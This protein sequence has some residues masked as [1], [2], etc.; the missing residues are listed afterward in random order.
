MPPKIRWPPSTTPG[1][2]LRE[3]TCIFWHRITGCGKICT[4]PMNVVPGTLP[5]FRKATPPNGVFPIIRK[6]KS[7][8]WRSAAMTPGLC[9]VRPFSAKNG[10]NAFS[11]FWKLT[12]PSPEQKRST[13][14]TC[15]WNWSTALRRNDFWKPGSHILKTFRIFTSTGRRQTR[16]M[17]LKIWKNCA[18][19]TPNTKTTLTMKPWSW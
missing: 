5:C 1:N 9:T 7:F 8:M 18:C 19:L 11:L 4:M 2:S 17:N 6:E 12:I 16:S 3:E 13:G 14:K 10:P 15:T